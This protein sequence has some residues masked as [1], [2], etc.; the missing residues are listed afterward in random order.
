MPNNNPPLVSIIIR[1]VRPELLGR[2]IDSVISQTYPNLEII[3]IN[4]G[5]KNMDHLIKHYQQ[6]VKHSELRRKITYIKN[7]RNVGRPAAANIGLEAATGD[8][9][10]FLDDDDYHYAEHVSTH[11]QKLQAQK[12]Q[13]S[14][15]KAFESVEE[16]RK[17]HYVE[18][19]KKYNYPDKINKLAY[20]FF[21]NYFPFNTIIFHKSL[22]SKTG[23]IDPDLQVLEDWDFI[24]RLILES[25]PIII[26][27]VTTVFTTRYGSSN[28]RMDASHKQ[29][30]KQTF[31][32]VQKKYN[33]YYKNS[34]V[35]IPIDEVADYLNQHTAHWYHLVKENEELRDSY[36]FKLYH[37]KIYRLAKKLGRKLK[38]TR[39]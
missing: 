24:I 21:E 2:A 31:S 8:Y 4:D 34:Q 39:G 37:S 9:I 11:I 7:T 1:T 32:R 36:A 13:V 19:E 28:I 25:E 33:R 30:W 14:I 26:N 35:A 17:K 20:Y 12:R 16:L 23:M 5:Q 3:I 15:S 6:Q 22:L 38:L 27:K 29:T 10:G 18:I